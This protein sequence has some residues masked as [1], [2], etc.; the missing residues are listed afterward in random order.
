[1]VLTVESNEQGR[2]VIPAEV[3]AALNVTGKA[4]WQLKV[5]DGAIILKPATVIPREDAWAYRPD[6]LARLQ[7]AIA[8]AQEGQILELS[9]EQ[10]A[11][12]TDRSRE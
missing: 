5:Q 4:H 11:K 12:L 10:L 2:L 8:Q 3:R 1:M 9:P 7:E 6:H